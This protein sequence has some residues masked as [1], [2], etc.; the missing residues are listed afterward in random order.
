[1]KVPSYSGNHHLFGSHRYLGTEAC[2][3]CVR[4]PVVVAR[5]GVPVHASVRV[6]L[7]TVCLRTLDSMGVPRNGAQGIEL[8][9][10]RRKATSTAR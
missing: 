10:L 8:E 6:L 2:S 1:M 9:K 7:W 5:V 4:I 3:G